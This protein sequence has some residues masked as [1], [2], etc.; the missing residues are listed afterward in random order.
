MGLSIASFILHPTVAKM[1]MP[2]TTE[3]HVE[4]H[5]QMTLINLTLPLSFNLLLLLLC[6]IFGFLTR[7]LPDNFNESWYIFISVSTTIF[8]WIAF[9]PTHIMAFY[10]YHKAALLSLALILNAAVTSLCL[11][12]PKIYA[13]YFVD[14]NDIKV[15]NFSSLD[16]SSSDNPNNNQNNNW[17]YI[18][19]K[20]FSTSTSSYF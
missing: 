7:K 8:I 15:T 13:V 17:I 5:C 3:K 11:F 12:V 1:T 16:F 9:L 20:A 4:L 6:A 19:C 2:V 10:A 14:E 18:I